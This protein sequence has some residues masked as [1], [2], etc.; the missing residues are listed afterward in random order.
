MAP[1]LGGS[2]RR[3]QRSLP[4]GI[5][6]S[7]LRSAFW[8]TPRVVGRP[9]CGCWDRHYTLKVSNWIPVW[10]PALLWPRCG[11]LRVKGASPPDDG[12]RAGGTLVQC[13]RPD[14]SQSWTSLC[15]LA[16]LPVT[17]DILERLLIKARWIPDLEALCPSWRRTT[18]C[19][20]SYSRPKGSQSWTSLSL[21][22][23]AKNAYGLAS[24]FL[25]G[26]TFP[27]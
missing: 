18:H 15:S 5:K 24:N 1:A 26:Q 10:V 16:H 4:W 7:S 14:R 17:E 21:H 13:S 25:C 23:Y 19:R 22:P 11:S 8:G 27:A 9:V 3:L 6:E 20:S 12:G 2:D